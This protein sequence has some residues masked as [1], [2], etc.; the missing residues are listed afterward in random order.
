MRPLILA[1]S[2]LFL[3]F[4]KS[5]SAQDNLKGIKLLM[6]RIDRKLRG[7]IPMLEFLYYFETKIKLKFQFSNRNPVPSPQ[8]PPLPPAPF[9]LVRF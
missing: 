9:S 1:S 6:K 7:A 2:F 4:S 8:P 3:V 5:S